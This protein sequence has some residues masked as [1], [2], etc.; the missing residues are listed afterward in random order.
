MQKLSFK[1]PIINTVIGAV[2][3]VFAIVALLLD[4]FSDIVDVIIAVLMIYYAVTHYV[5][6]KKKYK[7]S[8]ALMILTGQ[9]VVIIIIAIFLL[10]KQF[11]VAS[12]VNTSFAVGIT[13]YLHGFVY[14][15]ILQLLKLRSKFVEFLIYMAILTLGTYVLFGNPSFEILKWLMFAIIVAYGTLLLILGL[16]KLIKKK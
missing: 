13:L 9:A 16:E 6:A 3:I 11:D 7:N 4:W 10:L 15:L 1:N 12:I 5:N 8:Q 2:L 14:L